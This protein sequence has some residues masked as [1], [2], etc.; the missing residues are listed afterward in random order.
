MSAYA[1]SVLAA[2]KWIGSS[3]DIGS[4]AAI[5]ILEEKAQH[6]SQGVRKN[7]S[8]KCVEHADTYEDSSHRS[9]DRVPG[10]Q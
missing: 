6:C 1:Y 8:G 10:R 5:R 2:V 9:D 7:C 4:L 3:K